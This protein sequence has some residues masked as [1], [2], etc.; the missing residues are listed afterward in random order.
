M[1]Q[2]SKMVPSI[3][4]NETAVLFA[5]GP[6]L[7]K[8]VVETVRPYHRSGKVRAFGCNNSYDMVDYLDVHYACDDRWWDHYAVEALRI[9]PSK[10]HV[11][12]QSKESSDKYHINHIPGEHKTALW[13]EDSSKIHFGKNSGFQLLNLAYH[14]GIRNFILVG[15]NMGKIEGQYHY[16]GEHPPSFPRYSDFDKFIAEF[17]EIQPQIKSRVINCTPTSYLNAFVKKDLKETLDSV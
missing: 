8:E 15:Y 12:T 3:Y 2:W 16:F 1:V 9:L 6:S 10:C 5:T 7:T 17:N 11:W 13:I 4:P 14:Y